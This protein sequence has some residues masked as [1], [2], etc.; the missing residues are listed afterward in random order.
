MCAWA[1]E[2]NE[3]YN[4]WNYVKLKCFHK[5]NHQQNEKRAYWVREHP[6]H[7]SSRSVVS[8]IHAELT[9]LRTKKQTTGLKNGWRHNITYRLSV[10]LHTWNLH[11]LLTSV[12]TKRKKMGR[13]PEQIFSRKHTHTKM[14]KVRS[15]ER[16]KLKWP[17]VTAS[18]LSGRPPSV[19]EQSHFW[20]LTWR[21]PKH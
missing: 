12:T 16:C 20:A 9:Q 11:N 5:V 18:H 3:K 2:A 21:N 8:E 7:T 17:W 14:L 4:K 15:H 6:T 19:S 1:R 10:I 13:R